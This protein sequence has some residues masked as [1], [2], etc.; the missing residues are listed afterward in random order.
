MAEDLITGLRIGAIIL[1]LW[2][3]IRVMVDSWHVVEA[4]EQ[5]RQNGWIYWRAML[6]V[7]AFLI[8]FLF[9]P[10]NLLRVNGYIT[11]ETGFWML[12][13]GTAGLHICAYLIMIGL[14]VATGR[15]NCAWPVYIAISVVSVVYGMTAGSL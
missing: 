4:P 13:A 5:V 7:Q 15:K 3:G 12:S 14:D 2:L 11:E 10:E 6:L 9:S 1:W 8:V